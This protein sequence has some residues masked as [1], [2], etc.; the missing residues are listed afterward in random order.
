MT[1]SIEGLIASLREC[2]GDNVAVEVKS[3]AGGLPDSVAASLCA[4]ANLPGGGVLVLG[5]DERAGFRP[6]GLTD[7]QR[8]KQGLASKARAYVP[9]VRLTFEDAEV[10]GHPVVV[11]TVH[12]C[13]GS[14]KPC[15][16]AASG[17]AYLRGYDGDFRMSAEE[18][19]GM[20]AARMAPLAD[21]A[22]VDGSTRHDL[23]PDLVTG[24][25]Q[26][27]RTRDPL[28]LGRF[29]DDAELL[30]HAGV[31]LAD[32]RLSTAGL[33]ALGTHPQQFLPRFLL[34]VAAD[35]L[36]D[37]PPEVRARHQA[38][39]T[40]PI[41]H[42]LDGAL[43]WARTALPTT[44]RSRPDGRVEDRP[45]HPLVAFRE[46]VANALVHRDL[47]PWS[48]GLAVEVRLRPDRLVITSPGGLY[49]ITVDRLGHEGVTS[50]RNPRLASMCQHVR[51]PRSGV[52]VVEALAGGIP[53]TVHAL[54]QEGLPPARF[55][56]GGVRFTVVLHRTATATGNARTRAMGP[57]QER[58]YLALNGYRDVPAL[59]AEL[60]LAAS[61][62]RRHLA[63]LTAMGLVTHVGGRGRQTVYHRT[64]AS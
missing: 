26:E 1:I 62:I 48:A 10:D 43:D 45:V 46:L 12:E 31:V 61:T 23:D 40:G 14:A 30:H 47:H 37:D 3:A 27:V 2:G 13:D 9:P 5:L 54:Q 64:A 17:A 15:R 32:G 58:V 36:P 16:L 33:L 24:Y 60:N 34:Q 20:L 6:S 52:R 50:T 38:T 7:P 42:L 21:R 59:A 19:Q 25:L 56:D 28:G 53:T 44:I 29:R 35:P 49:G 8:L 55:T 41:P 22:P 4:L 18:E 51:T 39:L 11:A 63:A 57:G